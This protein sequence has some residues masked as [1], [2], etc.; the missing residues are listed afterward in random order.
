MTEAARKLSFEE[1][2]NLDAEDWVQFGLPEGRCEYFDGEIVELPTE[3]E[4]NDWVALILRDILIQ[5]INRRLVRIGRCE[6]ETSGRPRSRF[7]DLVV[8]REEHIPLTQKRLFITRTMAPPQL[9]AEVVS[10][11]D[12]NHRRDYEAKRQQYQ[13]RGI[14]EYWLINP[15]QKTVTVLHLVDGQYVEFG[16]FRQ[17]DRV[18]SASLGELNFTCDQFFL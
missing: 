1:Y 4:L 12:A 7:P 16:V 14:P 15:E 9:V 13:E 5:Y 6:V 18:S 3:S 8:L 11:G 10:P 17:G 2:A